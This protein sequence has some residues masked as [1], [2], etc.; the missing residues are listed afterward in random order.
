MQKE[1][2]RMKK[3]NRNRDTIVR[4]GKPALPMN[5]VRKIT[6]WLG[7]EKPALTMNLRQQSAGTNWSEGSPPSPF[8]SPPKERGW[9]RRVWRARTVSL[10]IQRQ[11]GSGVQ[12]ANFWFGEFTPAQWRPKPASRWFPE[13]SLSLRDQRFPSGRGGS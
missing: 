10:Q 8:P 2:G 1:E 12:S 7:G 6:G 4:I 13:N 3:R 11:D 9:R 5:P